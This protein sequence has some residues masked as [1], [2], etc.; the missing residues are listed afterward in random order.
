M[1]FG[2]QGRRIRKGLRNEVLPRKTTCDLGAHIWSSVHLQPD[3][4]TLE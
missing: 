2:K 4:F 3:Y 1:N